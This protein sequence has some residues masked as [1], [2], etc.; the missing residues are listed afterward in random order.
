[1]GF[2]H[3]HGEC[4][5]GVQERAPW[6]PRTDLGVDFV[7]VYGVDDTMPS[8]VRAFRDRGYVVHLMTGC[9]WGDYL[10]YFSGAWDGAP[11]WDESQFGRDGQPILH[12]TDTPYL[13][14]T[15]AFARYL[16]SR[17]KPAVDAGVEAVHLEEPEYWDAAGYGPAFKRAWQEEYG[18]PWRPPHESVESR[19]RA[20]ALKVLLFRRLI[21]EVGAGLKAYAKSLGRDL[22]LYVPTHSLVNYTQWKI[23][24]PEGTLLD[25]PD[26]DGCIAQVWT[27]TARCGNVYRGVYAE[28]TFET[29]FLEY[30]VMQELVR[31]TGRRM[32]FLHDPVED[33]PAYTWASFRDN[34]LRTVVASLLHPAVSRYEVCPWPSR[35]FCGVYP[36]TPL[37]AHGGL[38]PGEAMEEARPIPPA[39]AELICTLFR[40]LGDM[41]QPC[42]GFDPALPAIGVFMADSGL[43]QR[44]FPDSVP[45]TPE[46]PE[47]LNSRLF[48]LLARQRAGEDTRAASQSLMDE[49]AADPSLYN[50][51]VASGP[52]PHFFG[53]AMPLVKAGIPLRP[54][55]LENVLRDPACLSGFSALILSYEWMKPRSPLEHE[56]LAAWVRGGGTLLLVGDGGDPYHAAR[57]WWNSDGLSFADPARHL[58]RTLGLDPSPAEGIYPVGAGRLALR[59]LSPARITLSPRASDDWLRWVLSVAAPDFRPR[60]SFLLRR[61]PYRIAAALTE[62]PAED[63]PLTLRGCFADLF[64]PDYA[65]LTEK[66]LS[67]GETALLFDLEDPSLPA[68]RPVASTARIDSLEP[69][70]FG[71]RLL[72]RIP[73]GVRPRLRLRLP[74]PVSRAEARPLPEDSSADGAV[75]DPSRVSPADF[76]AEPLPDG[77]SHGPASTLASPLPDAPASGDGLPILPEAFVWDPP[78]RTLFLSFP[79]GPRHLE[80]LIHR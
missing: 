30:G 77:A 6:S 8:R 75:M 23:L 66:T 57:G 14:P 68:L 19:H 43:Y 79:A 72:C 20:S 33:N 44:S 36:K 26:V 60:G 5:T 4:L 18:E 7:M 80:I 41:D 67:P 65:V 12:G 48:A 62:S 47:G 10:D 24:S 34:Y 21:A 53:L 45:H 29:A 1:M 46:G 15:P 40:T 22:A 78:S 2:I 49:I 70:A 51:Y 71:F 50:D 54:V 27:G 3:D 28:R 16:L 61:G 25:V 64:S 9:A 59:R 39:Y 74:F 17:L 55:Q 38:I 31:A 73:E 42:Q 56:A 69:A 32:W 35:V 76:L 11:H 37:L 63:E 58:C 52:F 13:C